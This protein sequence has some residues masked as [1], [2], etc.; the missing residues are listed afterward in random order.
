MCVCVCE[1]G[2]FSNE[3]TVTVFNV[4][5]SKEP[6]K[7]QATMD[8]KGHKL[9]VTRYIVCIN[10]FWVKPPPVRLRRMTTDSV[11]YKK[12][13]TNTIDFTSTPNPSV[14]L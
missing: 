6:G 3:P 10:I 9:T 5:E 8:V 2:Q 14:G 4:K 1:T 11:Y 13:Y 12:R 7:K